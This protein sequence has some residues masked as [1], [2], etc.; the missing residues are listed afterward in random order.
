MKRPTLCTIVIGT[1]H[2]PEE[3]AKGP[4]TVGDL[5]QA[6]GMKEDHLY[7]MM[8]ALRSY[9]IFQERNGVWENNKESACLVK[10][11]P[12]SLYP[13]LHHVTYESYNGYIH[14]YEAARAGAEETSWMMHAKESM[15]TWF[16]KNE[17]ALH[18]FN[19]FMVESSATEMGPLM[20]D[21]DWA[22]VLGGEGKTVADIGGGKGHLVKAIMSKVP[23]TKG[24]VFDTK[25][26]I[27]D[28]REFWQGSD[29]EVELVVGDFFKGVP[30]ADVY[31]MKHILHDWNDAKCAEIL[32]AM[33][34]TVKEKNAKVL[35]IEVVLP[36][37]NSALTPGQAF[38]DLQMMALVDGKERTPSE[39][40]KL[41]SNS[42]Y[43]M[44]RIAYTKGRVHI[45]EAVAST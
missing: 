32:K 44:Q 14:M 42:G 27:A 13:M 31:T 23:G 4:R 20:D 3:L 5:A 1:G 26:M 29:A 28:A 39:W 16:G 12:G 21:Y 9:G 37:D 2:V 15:W 10:G 38:I 36:E 11:A 22:G 7:R 19:Q 34:P 18:N 43:E 41:F 8:R 45:V 33:H 35:V 24:I 17:E 40:R 6:T 25:D 30:P